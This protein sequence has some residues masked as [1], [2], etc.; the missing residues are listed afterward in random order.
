MACALGAEVQ[1]GA[2]YED[3]E[4]GGAEAEDAERWARTKVAF[5]ATQ[6]AE[7]EAA[8]EAKQVAEDAKRRAKEECLLVNE[9]A[10]KKKNV[11]P[12]YFWYL[13]EHNLRAQRNGTPPGIPLAASGWPARTQAHLRDGMMPTVMYHGNE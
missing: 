8:L 4:E 3:W 12:V 13:L 5:K 1:G 2:T 7:E 6:A 9:R 11:L 10:L